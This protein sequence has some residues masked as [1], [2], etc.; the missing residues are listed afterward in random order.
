[1]AKDKIARH[2]KK[3]MIGIYFLI[4]KNEVVYVGASIHVFR[5]I[6]THKGKNLDRIKKEFDHYCYLKCK[7][8]ELLYLEKVFIDFYKPLYNINKGGYRIR[9]GRG[10]FVKKM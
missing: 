1:M 7:E 8:E 5:R 6:S 4:Y 3:K 9:K 2:L 10:Y